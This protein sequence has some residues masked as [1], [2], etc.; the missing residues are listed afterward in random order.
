MRYFGEGVVVGV[1]PAIVAMI[2]DV[3]TLVILCSTMWVWFLAEH[4][5]DR[6]TGQKEE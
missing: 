5:A 2:Y 3:P 6:P 4:F 1:A